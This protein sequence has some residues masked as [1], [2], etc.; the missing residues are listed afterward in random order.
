MIDIS[1]VILLLA[2]PTKSMNINDTHDN[3]AELYFIIKE[4]SIKRWLP[5]H[6][7]LVFLNKGKHP[8]LGCY[9]WH[10]STNQSTASPFHTLSSFL[11]QTFEH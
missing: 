5:S 9:P 3:P 11:S 7:E 6:W 4:L 2:A 10:R 8:H 1:K